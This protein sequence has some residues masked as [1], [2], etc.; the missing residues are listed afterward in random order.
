MLFNLLCPSLTHK[1]MSFLSSNSK[2]DNC[3]FVYLLVHVIRIS[4]L[5]FGTSVVNANFLPIFQVYVDELV[6]EDYLSICTSLFPSICRSILSK[7]ILFN[8]QLFEETMSLQKFARDGSPWEFN[9]R[10]VIRSC[11]IIK[12]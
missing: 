5:A 3:F 4:F 12:G 9:L 1:L 6:E 10:D 11:E 8:K 2:C 7:L